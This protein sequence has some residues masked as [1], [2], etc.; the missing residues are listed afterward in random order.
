[1]KTIRYNDTAI[2]PSKVVC[3]GLIYSDDSLIL[4]C[5]WKVLNMCVPSMSTM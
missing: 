2:T 5:N 4:E 3:I 1:M